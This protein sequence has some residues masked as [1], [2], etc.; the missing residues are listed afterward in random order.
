M[1]FTD[2]GTEIRR[3]YIDSGPKWRVSGRNSLWTYEVPGTSLTC[4]KGTEF[5]ID[6]VIV[7]H[8]RA[9]INSSNRTL[10]VR[11]RTAVGSPVQY[12]NFTVLWMRA[13]RPLAA[14]R[15]N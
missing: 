4:K 5:A 2:S 14:S 12:S 8:G 11:I 10:R 9:P 13:H 3:L 15:R 6:H 1:A 7:P